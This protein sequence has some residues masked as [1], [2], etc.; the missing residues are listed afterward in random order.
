[1]AA[2]VVVAVST[3]GVAV[4][5]A[6][7]TAID[8][9]RPPAVAAPADRGVPFTDTAC[10]L[11]TV[12]ALAARHPHVGQFVVATTTSFTD[13]RGTLEIA[14][15]DPGGTWRC[16][17]AAVAAT[18]G[19]N[20]TRPLIQRRSG[21]GTTPAGVFPLGRVTAWDGQELS[22]FGNEPDPGSL[23]PYRAVRR[24]DCWGASPG[25]SRYQR[26]VN[27][28]GCSG[29][30]E[31][32]QA[33]GGAYAHAVVIGANL[34]PV[35]GDEPGEPPY[36]AAI[37]LHRNSYDGNGSSRPTSG[38][39]ALDIEPLVAAVRTIDPRLDPHFAIGPLD[40][41]RNTA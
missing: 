29:P 6:A 37:F 28:P 16:Q 9:A 32:L 3:A 15:R 5:T 25:T 4:A 1:V 23:A 10:D 24:E 35:S 17:Q 33:F 41:L 13:T 27:R 30:D 2:A 21:D 20:G 18:F 34:D 19:R 39:I 38:C 31:W 12:E 36:A 14:V 22:V 7:V 40:Y 11:V 26:L 8:S